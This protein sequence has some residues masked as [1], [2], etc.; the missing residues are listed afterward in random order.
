[1]EINEQELLSCL[2]YSDQKDFSSA[3]DRI[4]N[5]PALPQVVKSY[6]PNTSPSDFINHAKKATN[7]EE[8]QSKI[9]SP[10]VNGILAQTTQGFSFSGTENIQK[11]LRYLFISNHRDIVCDP[12]LFTNGLF[13][14]RFRTPKI[15]L[16]DNL[17]TSQLMVDLVKMNKGV[18]VKRNLSSRELLKWSYILSEII[19]REISSKRDSV[20]IAQREG[21]AKNGDDR[22]Q[23]G[24]LKMI[25][26]AGPGSFLEKIKALR[27][28]PVSISYEYDPCDIYKAKELVT[29]ETRGSYQKGPRE[30]AKSIITG[31]TGAKGRIHITLGKELSCFF[32]ET[33]E[34]LKRPDQIRFMVDILDREIHQNYHL[35]PSNYIAYDL[36]EGRGEMAS[37]NYSHTDYAFFIERMKKQVAKLGD[38]TL[39]PKQLENSLLAMYAQPVKNKYLHQEV[40]SKDLSSEQ[41]T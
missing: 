18:T 39:D 9:I 21:R 30:D 40:V 32:N 24:I 16:G 41:L 37:S 17:L 27:I 25:T 5:D 33:L 34:S 13:L 22:T 23:P 1:M 19:Y 11:D 28:I 35:W 38:S 14:H 3:L 8:F 15:C 20:W 6:F 12:G 2:P 36:L 31:I 4:L 29:I 10:I 26:L 7:T